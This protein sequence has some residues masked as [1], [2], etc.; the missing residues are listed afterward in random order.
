MAHC[1]NCGT[2]MSDGFCPNCEEEAFIVHTQSDYLPDPI[3]DEFRRLVEEQNAEKRRRAKSP[4]P[5]EVTP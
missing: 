5:P 1:A 3:S 2:K 4:S